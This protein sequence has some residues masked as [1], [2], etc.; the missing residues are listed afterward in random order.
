MKRRL[1]CGLSLLFVLSI[2]T[3]SAFAESPIHPGDFPSGTDAQTVYEELSQ[4][5]DEELQDFIDESIECLK[6][7]KND[8]TEKQIPHPGD[9][10]PGTDVQ[11]VYEEL[12]KLSDEELQNFID[13]S[14]ECLKNGENVNSIE[15]KQ[16]DPIQMAKDAWTA[17]ALLANSKGYPLSASLVICSINDNDYSEVNGKFADAIRKTS[18]FDTMIKNGADDGVF[19]KSMDPDLYY[20]IHK[21]SYTSSGGGSGLRICVHDL[22]NFE[23]D[24]TYEDL[25]SSI[26]NNYADLMEFA[27]V[28]N[29]IEV[30]INI[31]V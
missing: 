13:E 20:S 18:L 26:V 23:L 27:H 6:A 29:E 3:T 2:P 17:A 31:D 21:F 15:N 12:S 7:Q 5:S 9:F 25:F 14:I 11:T 1:A 8:D 30:I 16:L 24:T 4:L 28:L 19:T 10:A 22:F